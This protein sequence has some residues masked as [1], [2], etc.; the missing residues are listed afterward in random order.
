ME[1]LVLLSFKHS[2]KHGVWC[3]QQNPEIKQQNA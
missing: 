1:A 3:H 2:N